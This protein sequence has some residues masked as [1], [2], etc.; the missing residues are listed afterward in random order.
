[1]EARESKINMHV[2]K[3]NMSHYTPVN[4]RFISIHLWAHMSCR[5]GVGK[6][7]TSIKLKYLCSAN[8][9]MRN[10]LKDFVDLLMLVVFFNSQ[11]C[12]VMYLRNFMKNMKTFYFIFKQIFQ[13]LKLRSTQIFHTI[14]W[15]YS[16]KA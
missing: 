2:E 14:F 9:L 6:E 3:Q 5:K 7:Y 11:R 4:T 16:R 15:E 10:F 1:M 8:C 12:Q 13:F